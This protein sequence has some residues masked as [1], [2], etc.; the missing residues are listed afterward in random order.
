VSRVPE[1]D[2]T[3]AKGES[4]DEGLLIFE[5]VKRPLPVSSLAIAGPAR[6][7]YAPQLLLDNLVSYPAV[8][9]FTGRL[10]P[11]LTI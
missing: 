1:L 7:T 3:S 9:I 2:K 10:A 5:R 4:P 8:A 6:R 11:C